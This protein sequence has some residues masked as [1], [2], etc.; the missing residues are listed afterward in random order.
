[1]RGT[2]LFRHFLRLPAQTGHVFH[3]QEHPV[4]DPDPAAASAAFAAF[5]ITTTTTATVGDAS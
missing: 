2:A 5:A 1:M 4:P 3:S